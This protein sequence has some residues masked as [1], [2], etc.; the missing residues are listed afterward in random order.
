MCKSKHATCIYEKALNPL[1]LCLSSPGKGWD[2]RDVIHGLIHCCPMNDPAPIPTLGRTGWWQGHLKSHPWSAKWKLMHCPRKQRAGK[3]G[4]VERVCET[5][6]EHLHFSGG[7]LHQLS[8]SH[9]SLVD[10][11]W[12]IYA[13]GKPQL[14]SNKFFYKSDGLRAENI[15]PEG[16]VHSPVKKNNCFSQYQSKNAFSV[17]NGAGLCRQPSSA[18]ANKS[19][20]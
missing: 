8:L 5:P 6:L 7:T 16:L 9:H 20:D 14:D 2:Q 19:A 13:Y 4:G 12:Y 17:R 1:W 10:D 18:P 3:D 11:I 15:K